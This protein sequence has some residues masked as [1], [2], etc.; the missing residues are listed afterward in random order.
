MWV[1][2]ALF[3]AEKC[4]EAELVKENIRTN[5]DGAKVTEDQAKGEEWKL[6]MAIADLHNRKGFADDAKA[7]CERVQKALGDNPI[8]VKL[9]LLRRPTS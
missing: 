7:F 8:A 2:A 4:P 3:A 5:L 6:A 9:P 1:D